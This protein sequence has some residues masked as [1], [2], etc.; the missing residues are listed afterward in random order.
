MTFDQLG[1]AEPLLR[2]VAAEGYTVPTPIQFQAIPRMLAGRDLLGCAQ[3]GTGKTA[4]FALPILHRLGDFPSS[5]AGR[6]RPIRVLVLAPTRELAQQISHS[7][8]AYGH[9]TGLRNTVVVGGVGQNPQR[10]ALKRGID[11]LIATPGRLL[12]L[13]GQG[14][15]DLKSVEMFVLDE[16]DRMLDMGFIPDI[17]RIIA[18]LPQRRQTVLFSATMP[19]SIEQLARAILRKPAQVRVAQ[20]RATTEL[21]EQSVAFVPRQHKTRVVADLL[22]TPAV[23]RA[24]VFT[25][26][27]HG[28]DRLARQLYQLGISAGVLHGAKSQ[29]ARQRTLEGFKS[30]RTAV[31]VA[32]DLAARGIDVEGI[33][34]V[35][36]YDLPHEAETYVH[37]IGRTGRAGVPGVAIAFCDEE[38]RKHLVAIQRL[39]GQA[40]SVEKKLSMLEAT[41]G[42]NQRQSAAD[43]GDSR[44]CADRKEVVHPRGT[45]KRTPRVSGRPHVRGKNSRT[46]RRAL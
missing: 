30:G 5:P 1:L 28:A 42:P 7:F 43:D 3:T 10:L 24:L 20:V 22:R 4:A 41:A 45:R 37:R 18:R 36:N 26:T 9:Y 39:I 19:E 13:M 17:R 35:V 44:E 33:S 12:D 32:T 27:K 34:H 14:L 21:I 6:T 16:A 40:L 15:V 25:R 11:I 46:L 29:S 2:A 23:A 31:L 38:E 8:H